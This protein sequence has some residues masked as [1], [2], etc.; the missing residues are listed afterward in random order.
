[1]T[2]HVIETAWAEIQAGVMARAATA[3]GDHLR[4]WRLRRR[5]SQM[6]LAGEAEVSTG[7]LN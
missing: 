7:R 6:D 2:S 1:M 3:I 4:E 5:M